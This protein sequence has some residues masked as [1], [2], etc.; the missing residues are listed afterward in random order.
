MRLWSLNS[1][2][3]T[4][5][6]HNYKFWWNQRPRRKTKWRRKLLRVI[7][8]IKPK[9]KWWRETSSDVEWRN[10][11]RELQSVGLY[12]TK[13]LWQERPQLVLEAANLS[14][15]LENSEG[16]SSMWWSCIDSWN[17]AR[18]CSSWVISQMY[19]KPLKGFKQSEIIRH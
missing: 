6:K 10:M 11:K 19:S 14:R 9:S 16:G 18:Y 3:E 12:V 1:S 8:M 17:Y 15:W 5:I 2:R 13:S 4:Y 7:T